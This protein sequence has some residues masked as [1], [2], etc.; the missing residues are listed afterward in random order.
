MSCNDN[1]SNVL[2]MQ[3]TEFNWKLRDPVLLKDQI[4]I[5]D[6][7]ECVKIKIGDGITNFND[8]KYIIDTEKIE[9]LDD[10]FKTLKFDIRCHLIT[11]W[12]CLIMVFIAFLRS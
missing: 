7:G 3:D 8:L 11:L 9:Y 1:E 12:A 5:V 6:C 4:A 2:I 10:K